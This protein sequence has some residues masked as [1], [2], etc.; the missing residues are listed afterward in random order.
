MIN[1]KEAETGVALDINRKPTAEEAAAHP[2]VQAIIKPRIVKL[3]EI[4]DDFITALIK[5]LEAVPYGIRWICRQVLSIAISSF[6][7]S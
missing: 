6:F 1:Q 3:K 7:G 4:T 2:E 5:S